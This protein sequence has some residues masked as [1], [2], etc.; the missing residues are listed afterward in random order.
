MKGAAL[1][2]LL[3]LPCGAGCSLPAGG[4][5]PA[6]MSSPLEGL[7][8]DAVLALEHGLRALWEGRVEEALL[9]LEA[10]AQSYPDHLPLGIWLQE[11]RLARA[12]GAAPI[13]G[14]ESPQ[15]RVRRAYRME[16]ER[17]PGVA[18]LV[19]AARVEGDPPSALLLLDRAL[20]LDPRSAWAHYGRAHVLAR[21]G[22]LEEA[23]RA[24]EAALAIEPGHLPARRL[25]AW[26]AA[27]TGRLEEAMRELENWLEHAGQDLLLRPEQRD[28]ARLDL[29]LLLLHA[30]RPGEALG[31]LEG[32]AAQGG[33]ESRRSAARAVALEDRGDYLGALEAARAAH[34]ADPE[35]L[36]PLV[37]Q[38]L[39]LERRLAD[40]SGALQAWE[41][42]LTLADRRED[43]GS[44]LQRSRAQVH[45]ERLR[46]ARS[47]AQSLQN[48]A[49]PR[50]R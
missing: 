13:A 49:R 40:P 21:R 26:M 10:L 23:G 11:A 47:E 19:L 31:R 35:D 34:A 45:V 18:A 7:E 27:R 37:Q 15:D 8:R 41:E 48:G 5:T 25:A 42:V 2:A 28:E 22:D 30:D 3:L 1:A 16:A 38:A 32:L 12:L 33:G 44:L 14:P 36:L 6:P 29:V 50:G 46:R 39:I 9:T 24:L 4:S 17:Q 43:L 20:E